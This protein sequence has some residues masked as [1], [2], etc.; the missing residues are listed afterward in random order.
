MQYIGLMV[1]FVFIEVAIAIGAYTQ[2]DEIPSMISTTWPKL[3]ND[4]KFTLQAG[5][6]CC[7]VNNY[8]E[9]GALLDDLPLS[10]FKVYDTL[11]V[12]AR[13]WTLLFRTPC[14]QQMEN[15]FNTNLPIWVTILILICMI[16]FVS[17]GLGVT[18][19]VGI[20][21]RTKVHPA[22]D[23]P[24]DGHPEDGATVAGSE[25][26]HPQSSHVSEFSD[27]NS[28]SS[29]SGDTTTRKLSQV[30]EEEEGEC[31][32]SGVV[33]CDSKDDLSRS[34]TCSPE[35][36]LVEDVKEW[37]NGGDEAKEEERE[38]R[39]EE[40]EDQKKEE[41]RASLPRSPDNAENP[42]ALLVAYNEHSQR[43][44]NQK[45]PT[46]NELETAAPNGAGL[47]TKDVTQQRGETVGKH[48]EDCYMSSPVSS[49]QNVNHTISE[50]KVAEGPDNQS[51]QETEP[52]NQSNQEKE[53]NNQSNQEKGA[54]NQL[55]REKEAQGPGDRS[56]QEEPPSDIVES[57]ETTSMSLDENKDPV[58]MA[59]HTGQRSESQ[60]EGD[61]ESNPHKENRNSPI[62]EREISPPDDVITM[63]RSEC[64]D[65]HQENEKR[66]SGQCHVTTEDS[67]R[68]VGSEISRPRDSLIQKPD[69]S[70][71]PETQES[72]FLQIYTENSEN[73]SCSDSQAPRSLTLSKEKTFEVTKTA[74]NPKADD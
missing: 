69:N 24:D 57:P 14:L 59:H 19:M 8:T 37:H 10:C 56:K 6:E 33:C 43:Y 67:D 27:Q 42:G 28:L 32:S 1:A 23:P 7:G 61:T 66:D 4:T 53:A 5:L 9:Y 40:H 44:E 34:R 29:A 47:T 35:N 36:R 21:E 11:T 50:K 38:E 17:M 62:S 20:E 12:H 13:S 46:M 2:Q 18:V 55:K 54:D 52:D 15:W 39:E 16:Q 30:P 49:L 72:M 3:N 63:K 41:E 64:L 73:L 60:Q 51:N 65:V 45:S 70:P 22:P 31:M 48:E 71:G 25:S 58:M 26:P 68:E 74:T